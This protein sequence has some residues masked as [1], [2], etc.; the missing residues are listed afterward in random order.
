MHGTSMHDDGLFCPRREAVDDVSERL[1]R[2][3]GCLVRFLLTGW[4]EGGERMGETGWQ[5]KGV[6]GGRLLHSY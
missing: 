3:D 5:G 1:D 2:V 4:G 6:R